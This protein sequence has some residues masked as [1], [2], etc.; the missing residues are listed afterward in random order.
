MAGTR[1]LMVSLLLL[2][3]A[4]LAAADPQPTAPAT[5]TEHRLSPAE[6]ER[7][8]EEAARKREG[9]SVVDPAQVVADESE[10]AKPG[11]PVHG[12]VGVSIGTGGYRSVYGTA[13]MPLPDDGFAILSFESSRFPTRDTWRRVPNR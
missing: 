1:L 6:V 8:L 5:P 2:P 10:E 9:R 11:L 13:F 7:I 3:G 12:E 4:A